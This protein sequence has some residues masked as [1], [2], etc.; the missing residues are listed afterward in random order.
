MAR[1][2]YGRNA[3]GLPAPG[4]LMLKSTVPII[5]T[6]VSDISPVMVGPRAG[7]EGR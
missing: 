6:Q 2:T 1:L 5:G 4:T 3:A 7:N